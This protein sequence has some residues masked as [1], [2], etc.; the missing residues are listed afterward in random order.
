M[1]ISLVCEEASTTTTPREN[2]GSPAA[3]TKANAMMEHD[4]LL[5]E[6]DKELSAALDMTCKGVG[7][8]EVYPFTVALIQF[9]SYVQE[10]KVAK[11]D[12]LEM[13]TDLHNNL[14]KEA[15]PEIGG[16]KEKLQNVQRLYEEILKRER[17]NQAEEERAKARA[18]ELEEAKRR[19]QEE[20]EEERLRKERE[21]EEAEEEERLRRRREEEEEEKE[22]LRREQEAE[23][24]EEEARQML[25]KAEAME[26]LWQEQQQQQQ[27]DDEPSVLEA[28]LDKIRAL[29]DRVAYLTSVVENSQRIS[30]SPAPPPPPLYYLPAPTSPFAPT[31]LNLST[32]SAV[33]YPSS[34]LSEFGLQR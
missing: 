33:Y 21:E 12:K 5:E 30:P 32:T 16:V 8:H 24:E 9:Q 13:F 34:P 18:K 6:I 15:I 22:R 27:T 28:L 7:Q 3:A 2:S 14:S 29:D 31:S 26:L 20:E 23:Q 4:L 10:I 11:R 19:K 25:A 17:R 1:T